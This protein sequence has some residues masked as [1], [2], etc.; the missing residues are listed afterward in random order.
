MNLDRKEPRKDFSIDSLKAE[1]YAATYIDRC[2][3][4]SKTDIS[5]EDA[6]GV[7]SAISF[8]KSVY[9]GKLLK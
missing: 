4:R 1:G 5:G 9:D 8:L 2:P 3:R 7:Y 6:E